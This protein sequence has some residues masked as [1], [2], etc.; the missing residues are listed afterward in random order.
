MV[1][2]QQTILLNHIKEYI[3]ENNI[4]A[5]E[6]NE[7]KEKKFLNNPA[8][9]A[10]SMEGWEVNILKQMDSPLSKYKI[11]GK[12]LYNS[13]MKKDSKLCKLLIKKVTDL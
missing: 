11:S 3:K 1:I 5:E 4:K 6:R 12:T 2:I 13:I 7:K 9:I 8:V 10:A